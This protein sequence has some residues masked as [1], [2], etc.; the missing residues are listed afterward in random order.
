[1]MPDFFE[2][3]AFGLI[4]GVIAGFIWSKVTEHET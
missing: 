3:I 1:M 4:H 2:M